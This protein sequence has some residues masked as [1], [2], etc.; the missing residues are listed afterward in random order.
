M[1][2]ESHQFLTSVLD[3]ERRRED[4]AFYPPGKEQRRQSKRPEEPHS[5]FDLCAFNKTLGTRRE[6][7]PYSP[8][9]QPISYAYYMTKVTDF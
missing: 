7:I 3:T 4:P 9:F 2:A 8:V 1:K 5:Q 6:S